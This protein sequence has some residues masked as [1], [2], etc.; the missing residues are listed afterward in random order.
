VRDSALAAGLPDTHPITAPAESEGALAIRL[1][2]WSRDAGR[3]SLIYIA[4]D[5]SRAD[6]IAAALSGLVPHVHVV[7]FPPWDCL[8]Y[9]RASPSREIMGRR[10]AALHAL[11]RGSAPP[12]VLLT[13][14]EAA[15][16]RVPPREIVRDGVHSV[17]VADRLELDELEAYLRRA[18]Y[19]LDDRVDEPGEAAI[20]GEVIDI[21]PPDAAE[22]S[23]IDYAE[24]LASGIR[25]YDPATQR[26]IAAAEDLLL[27]PASE[28]L[29]PPDEERWPGIEHALPRFYPRLETIFDYLPD[30]EVM[31]D[32]GLSEHLNFR[33]EQVADA[34]E[35]R[36]LFRPQSPP[37]AATEPREL[38]LGEAEW[39]RVLEGRRVTEVRSSGDT[40]KPPRFIADAD[41]FGA[42]RRFVRE[43]LQAGERVLLTAAS[44]Q[45]LRRLERIAPELPTRVADWASR[46]SRGIAA[47][48]VAL[49][50][51]FAI[52][53]ATVVAAADVF[54]S[55]TRPEASGASAFGE[56]TLR[57]G[58]AVI[59]AEHG[60][61]ILKGVETVAV[62]DQVEDCLA[63]EY[64][65]GTKL[66]VPADEA[67]LLWRYGSGGADLSLDRLGGDD[68]KKRSAE[69]AAQ[70]AETARGLVRLT[71]E[72]ERRG[73]PRLVPPGNAYRRF[74][75]RFA[76][77]E[78]PDQA[79][80]IA[81]V[82][83][84][85]A[86]G[87]PMDRLVC[88]DV[89]FG[90]T[91]VALRAAAAAVFAGKQVAVVAP[92][93]V[94][95]RQHLQT[96]Q[97]RF[98][99]L[100]IEIVQLSRLLGRAE[101]K[102]AKARLADGSARI[103]IGTHALAGKAIRFKELGLLVVDEEQRFGT[104][105]KE[106][107]RAL[108]DGVHVLTMTATPIP[109]TL[110]LALVGIQELS[111]IATPPVRRLP[112][113]TFV[114]PF[115]PVV[116]RGALLRERRRGGQS[117][118]VCP[119]IQ[120]IEPLAAQL[121]ELVPELEL[122]VA[123]GEMPTDELD[124][125]MV[126]FASGTGDVLLATNIIETGLDV[127][128]A[129]T[130]LVWRPDR[131]GLAQLHQLRGRVGRGRV[132][133]ACYFL[134]DPTVKVPPATEKR[135]KNLETLD[136][137]GA[138][139]AVSAGDLDLRGAGD[140]LGPDQAGHVKLIGLELYQH[141]FARA[142]AIARG[143]SL[144]DNWCPVLQLEISGLI[145]DSY[146]PEEEVRIELYRRIALI[147]RQ[148]ELDELE[149]EIEDRFGPLPEA[150]QNLL[151]I[152]GLRCRARRSGIGKIEAG[153]QAVALTF[154][155]PI[156][157]P[158]DRIEGAVLHGKKLVVPHPS[159]PG[160]ARLKGIETILDELASIGRQPEPPTAGRDQEL[161]TVLDVEQVT[162]AQPAT[163][164]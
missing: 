122:V 113:R 86:S 26:T 4:R 125:A 50:T 94:L 96:F 55:P 22:P 53:G 1:G 54:R 11:V 17:R 51:G 56:T 46:P 132:R 133:A 57:P 141:F 95:V 109:R 19:L 48:V 84:D 152:A 20:R 127:P 110:Q 25:R 9:D 93:T 160:P 120:D 62:G 151:R 119:R 10:M 112:V 144:P 42:A 49:D 29:L 155:G 139:F 97:S 121:R 82:L 65:K 128:A 99:G 39:L 70:M 12:I 115:D 157:V 23:R 74:V 145:P 37:E 158:P 5:E 100:G 142:I 3:D 36:R 15:L 35:T 116:A 2:N 66:L 134:F 126:G 68:W 140:L 164:T 81:S 34:W 43:R 103:A 108:A 40:P 79:C 73:A 71:R 13:T 75:R 107:L 136:R 111:I 14:M 105:E 85:L 58:D 77:R 38:Y 60:L 153:P 148:R 64:A 162:L 147:L 83:D 18:G 52:D 154:R 156:P 8:P 63:I 118:V 32:R 123:H 89:G 117:F 129:N 61:G 104:Q 98:A 90:K 28:V 16:Q 138:G 27:T 91:E 41:P 30:A 106:R 45:E 87:R 101:A 88:G 146:V 21:F 150:L 59:H 44:E 72:R 159:P 131:F 67:D 161:H 143:E 92:T 80:A 24:G 47:M 114:A 102:R 31:L 124:R 69:I 33:L 7:V 163:E 76:H 135:L 78:T 137:L 149:A 130:M 6:R